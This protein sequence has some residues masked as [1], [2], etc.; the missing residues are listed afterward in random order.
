MEIV[1]IWGISLTRRIDLSHGLAIVPIGDLPPSRLKD[2]L[3]GKR[4]HK[5]SF[6]VAN[7]SPR[8]GAAIIRDFESGPLY[9]PPNSESARINEEQSRLMLAVLLGPSEEDKRIAMEGLAEMMKSRVRGRGSNSAAEL[10]EELSAVIALKTPK[11]IFPLGHWYQRP[12]DLPLVGPLGG[13]SGPT[14]EHPFYIP[15]EPQEYAY[16]EIEELVRRFQTLDA[17]M[18][19]RLRTPLSRLNQSRRN[20]EHHTVEDAA[21]DLG[22]ALEAMLTFDRDH[23]APISYL[24]RLRGALLLGGD[25]NKRKQT[26]Q[27]LRDAYDVRSKVVHNGMIADLREVAESQQARKNLDDARAHV[28]AGQALCSELAA[29]LIEAGSFPDWDSLLLGSE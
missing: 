1:P 29:R 14:N 27:V 6:D 13:W 28:R 19:K 15:V 25:T 10:S 7:S 17:A 4:R 16:R 18:R 26:F 5:F 11:P 8:P 9:E 2:L 23:N 20:V 12:P 21:I 3:M 22:I 24:L